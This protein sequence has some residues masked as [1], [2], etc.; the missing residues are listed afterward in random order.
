MKWFLLIA[1][2]LVALCPTYS[3]AADADA[4][5]D[6]APA[7]AAS[8]PEDPVAAASNQFFAK[9]SLSFRERRRLGLTIPKMAGAL[10]SLK[11]KGELEPG[12]DKALVAAMVFEELASE[13]MEAYA[14]VDLDL[15]AILAF[16]EKFLP[17][18]MKILDFFVFAPTI[19][20]Q[21]GLCF[22]LPVGF[23]RIH[24]G[25]TLAA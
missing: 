19:V 11:E 17:I 10:K 7:V 12:M 22:L 1:A 6:A 25:M 14:A 2:L 3:F 13:N 16:I 18:L 20:S 9:D 15:D 21:I 4:D 23:Q 5:T 24:R 8:Q